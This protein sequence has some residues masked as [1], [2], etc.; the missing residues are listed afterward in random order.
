VSRPA[1]L[2]HR[3]GGQYRVRAIMT[4]ETYLYAGETLIVNIGGAVSITVTVTDDVQSGD[5]CVIYTEAHMLQKS[6]LRPKE[7]FYDGRFKVVRP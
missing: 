3:N 2:Q 1:L 6:W 5:D 7:M 4:S